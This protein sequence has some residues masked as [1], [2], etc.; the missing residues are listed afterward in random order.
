[1]WLDV[2]LDAQ[3]EPVGRFAVD[4]STNT[5][6]GIQP[7]QLATRALI[8]QAEVVNLDDAQLS[9]DLKIRNVTG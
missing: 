8:L 7:E 4:L 3:F 2:E 6:S 5:V 1:M 9:T